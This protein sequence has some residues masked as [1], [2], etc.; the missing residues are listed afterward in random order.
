[1]K[2]IHQYQIAALAGISAPM[3][4]Q[5]ISGKAKPSWRTAKRLAQVT[6]SDPVEW[7]ESPPETLRIIIQRMYETQAQGINNGVQ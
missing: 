5:I 6:M 3:F 7:M 4:C 2:K 1:M